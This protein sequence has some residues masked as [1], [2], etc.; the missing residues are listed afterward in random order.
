MHC[1]PGCVNGTVTLTPCT[2]TTT[3]HVTK[4]VIHVC[5]AN[6]KDPT[7]NVRLSMIAGS[8]AG[9]SV[10]KRQEHMPHPSRHKPH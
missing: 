4:L 8:A 5:T 3:P 9:L 2:T 7:H 6:P 10:H 1:K